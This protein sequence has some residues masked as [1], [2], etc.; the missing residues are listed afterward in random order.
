MVPKAQRAAHHQLELPA[1]IFG[2]VEIHRLQRELESLENYLQQAA[3]REPGQQAP[4]PRMSRIME[5]LAGGNK[6]NLLQSADRET[7]ATFLKQVD[8]EAPVIH[9]S[10]AADPSAAFTAKVVAWLRANI[11]PHALLQLGLQPTLAAG[12]VIRTANKS[13]DFSLRH[14]FYEQRQVLLTAL[15][16]EGAPS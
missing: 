3:V 10:L 5:T 1:I 2:S 16:S 13:F 6:L 4:L 11:H 12:C 7:L 14:R 9:M 15:A 8:Q